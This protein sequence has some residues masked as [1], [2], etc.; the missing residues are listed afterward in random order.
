MTGPWH[1]HVPVLGLLAPQAPTD[2]YIGPPPYAR[3]PTIL[4]RIFPD[5]S[6]GLLSQEE[7]GNV[8][9]QGLGQIGASLMALGG[10]QENQRGTIANLGA[11]LGGVDWQGLTENALKM[12]AYQQ[13]QVAGVH[14][15]QVLARVGAKWASTA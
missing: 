2:A 1:P 13:Q 8:R 10:P 6:G 15:Q 5:L 12:R 4:E 14:A 7:Q 3:K 11:A 9:S